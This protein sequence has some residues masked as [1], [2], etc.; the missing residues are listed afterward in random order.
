MKI[1]FLQRQPCVRAL[2]YAVSLR[3]AMPEIELGFAY[4][5][6][7]LTE[8]YGTGDELFD[9]W[10]NLGDDAQPSDELQAVLDEF[11]PD[12][13]H[14]HNLPDVLTVLALGLVD[15]AI[16]LVHDIHDLQS[17]RA[18]PYHDG[19]P[20]PVDPLAL[21]RAAIEGAAAVITVS[22]ELVDVV[23]ARYALPDRT[24]VLGN[25]AL[26]RD[27]VI[28]LPERY[29]ETSPRTVV[30]EG[31]LAAD[32]GHY[33]LRDIFRSVANAGLSLAIHPS[34]LVAEYVDLA[35]VS[36]R[37]RCHDSLDPA[38]L[39]R[40]LPRYDLGWAG[41]NAT[42]NSAHLDT[43]LPNKLY[44]YLGAGLPVITM[45]DHL[46]LSRF[47]DR[48]GVGIVLDDIADIGEAV[49]ELDMPAVRQTVAATRDR[50]TFEAQV[51]QVIEL[52]R[53]LVGRPTPL[54]EPVGV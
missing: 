3:G 8:F 42:L 25:L 33:D 18:T 21:E 51:G 53:D 12:L 20:E 14:S 23:N 38:T 16:P 29:D 6:R 9:G 24:L 27:R 46:A 44:E 52:Y 35:L 50:Y 54:G 39:M 36:E 2:K 5:G 4:Q 11:Q 32:G 47:V 10:W 45:R 1:L 26:R 41:F 7:T 30:Y 48:E 34:R 31:S 37:I 19:F 17:L 28:D 49:R 15:G 43:V 13:I 40:T 22:P